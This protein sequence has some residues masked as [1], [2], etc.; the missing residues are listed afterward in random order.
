MERQGRDSHGQNAVPSETDETAG[1][2][3]SGLN[4]MGNG[5]PSPRISMDRHGGCS[6]WYACCGFARITMRPAG[7][8]GKGG[9]AQWPAICGKAGVAGGAPRE[10]VCPPGETATRPRGLYIRPSRPGPACLARP[11]A[12]PCAGSRSTPTPPGGSHAVSFSAPSRPHRRHRPRGP[13]SR[14]G[15]PGPSGQSHQAARQPGPP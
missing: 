5:G 14:P 2:A 10:A 12:L 9:G 15:R 4:G 13:R 3:A 8:H 11:V 1:C 7:G 6:P